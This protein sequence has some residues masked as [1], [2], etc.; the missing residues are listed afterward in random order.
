MC[1]S[2]KAE[3]LPTSEMSGLIFEISD[4]K[5]G[6]FIFHFVYFFQRG[7]KLYSFLSCLPITL[8]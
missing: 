1:V 6:I 5:V 7:E 2:L 4:L 3:T 8:G